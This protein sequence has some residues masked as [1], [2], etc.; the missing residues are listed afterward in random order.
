[1]APQGFAIGFDARDQE[2]MLALW[3]EILSSNRWSEGP[4]TRRFEQRWSEWNGLAALSFTSWTG[5]AL[6]ALEFID[7]R[8]ETVLC[9]SNTYM[10]TPMSVIKS[11][12]TVAFVYC[13]REDLCMSFED[14]RRKAEKLKP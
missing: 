8:G 6:A 7:V 14:F 12:G 10:A 11:G 5:A 4:W 9:P 2:R 1:V 3:H 13:N